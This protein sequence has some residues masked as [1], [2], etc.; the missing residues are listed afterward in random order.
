MAAPAYTEGNRVAGPLMAEDIMIGAGS[1]G[2]A[3]GAIGSVT[4]PSTVTDTVSKTGNWSVAGVTA[5]MKVEGTYIRP[6]TYVK[7]AGASTDLVLTRHPINTSGSAITNASLIFHNPSNNG[8]ATAATAS[9]LELVAGSN[10]T[11]A[12]SSSTEGRPQYTF[13]S[14]A[15]GTGDVEA[16]ANFATDNVL[17]RSDGT[18]KGVQFTGI[19]V[20]DTTDNMSGIGTLS[21][22]A[23]TSTGTSIFATLDISGN[24]DVD[25]TTNL[26]AVD[27][28]GAVQL[29]A[30]LTVGAN[31]QGYD[32]KFFGDTDAAYMMWDTNVDDLVLAGAAGIDL[33][34]DIDVDGTANLD[35]VD[36]DGTVQIDGATTFGV[37]GTG[38]DVKFFGDTSGRYSIWDEGRDALV[39]TDAAKIEIGTGTDMTLY[40][41]GSNSYITN[42]VGVLKIA[43]ETSGIAITIGHG[44][45]E[46]TVAD[47]L[48]VTG[49]LSV[50]GTTTT[51]SSTVSTIAD[52]LIE[53]NTGAGSNANDLG[54]IM[55][56]G[57]TGNNACFLWDESADSFVVGTTT[58]TGA[59]TGN[60]TFAAAKLQTGALTS[61][62]IAA[63]TGTFSG[64]L[65]TDDTTAATTTTDGSLQTDGGLSVVL[66]A[67]IGDD[68]FLKSD[69]A[70]FN[71]GAGNDFTI[72]HDGTTGA[73]L[74]GNPITLDSA[75][76]LTLDAGDGYDVL[77][78]EAGTTYFSVGLGSADIAN[79]ADNSGATAIDVFDCTVY[80]AVKYFILVED[81]T[82][83]D[84]MTAEILLLGDDVPSTAVAYM[85][86]YAVIWNSTELGVFTATGSGNNI[87][88][89][90]DPKELGSDNHRVRVVA[91]RI[92]SISDSG[93]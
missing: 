63:T 24:I 42:A 27:I 76:N 17:I 90:Y 47:N 50:S 93:Q 60:I 78:K 22:G 20:A 12:A 49:N 37:N 15:S 68:L 44:T 26:D 66:D 81:I 91:Q 4:I 23:I 55:E 85:T 73:T 40:H 45:S 35:N 80:Q 41:D 65:K 1:N 11:I 58:A 79:I 69:S 52:P 67:V 54:F 10:I 88:L 16:A 72:T 86:I 71:M 82:N 31:D 48:T 18:S 46:V 13:A 33:A 38:V 6:N 19:T 14:T 84:Y 70:V 39:F 8:A 89:N 74:A 30:T 92:A 29:D 3:L 59:S 77:Y 64:V 32:V 51:I 34:G 25:G 7:T 62:T 28:D 5:G 21:C 87:T 9:G 57:S 43:T 2:T 36:I 61:T 53:L 75:A 83:D 56:R